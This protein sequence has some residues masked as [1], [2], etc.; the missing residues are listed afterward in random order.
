MVGNEGHRL[1][2][3]MS[4]TEELPTRHEVGHVRVKVPDEFQ[5]MVVG[6]LAL[7][8]VWNV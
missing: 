1:D 7:L 6:A 3:P 5:T 8:V 4:A 2:P